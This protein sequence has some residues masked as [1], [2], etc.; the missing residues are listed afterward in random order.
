MNNKQTKVTNTTPLGKSEPHSVELEQAIL[1]AALIDAEAAGKL[2]EKLVE[3]DFYL[4]THRIIYAAAARLREERKPVDVV[5]VAGALADAGTLPSAGGMEYVHTLSEM[6]PSGAHSDEYIRQIKEKARLRRL[7]G[8]CGKTIA[9]AYGNNAFDAVLTDTEN[10]LYEMRKAEEAHELSHVRQLVPGALLEI[11]DR[12]DPLKRRGIFT[13]FYGVDALLHGLQPAD[14][15]LLA[16]RPS[17]GKTMFAANIITNIALSEKY[18][19]GNSGRYSCALFSLEMSKLQIVIR[20]LCSIGHISMTKVAKGDLSPDENQKLLKAAALLQNSRLFIDDTGAI[21]PDEIFRKCV[22][23]KRDEGLD[24]IVIDYLQLM[25]LN[26]RTEN[27]TL[28]IA[29]ITRDLKLAAKELDVPVLLLSQLSRAVE[30]RDDKKPQLSDLRDS[31]AIE[32]DADIVMFIHDPNYEKKKSMMLPPEELA[33]R[34]IVV[35]KH[36][37]GALGVVD[38]V[39][40]GEHARF[41]EPKTGGYRESLDATDPGQKKLAHVSGI[42]SGLPPDWQKEAAAALKYDAAKLEEEE[43]PEE[44]EEAL[45]DDPLF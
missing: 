26:K 30:M 13:K 19:A 21:T 43:K 8:V 23:L 39:M 34:Q 27:R 7:I 45:G 29:K 5:T 1:G 9:E 2:A 33:R 25:S 35:A 41:V 28:E 38:L 20:M 18:C 11:A 14:L 36:R 32:Q 15:I 37:N 40:D 10:A 4:E 16:A 24:I 17:A 22:R 42:E 44:S 6:V 3:T 31:G 12:G